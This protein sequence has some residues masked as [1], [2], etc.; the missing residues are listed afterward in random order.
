MSY[1]R[2]GAHVKNA[3]AKSGYKRPREPAARVLADGES[4]TRMAQIVTDNKLT[5]DQS[6]WGE[7]P[8]EPRTTNKYDFIRELRE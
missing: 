5:F 6:W 3:K 7:R 2:K 8:R 4:T 1:L